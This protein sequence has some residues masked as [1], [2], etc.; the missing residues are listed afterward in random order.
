MIR[1]L[2][3]LFIVRNDADQNLRLAMLRCRSIGSAQEQDRPQSQKN[4]DYPQYAPSCCRHDHLLLPKQASRI[5]HNL[6]CGSFSNLLNSLA[7]LLYHPTF[8]ISTAIQHS[9]GPIRR[10]RDGRTLSGL[11]VVRRLDYACPG[12]GLRDRRL[13]AVCETVAKIPNTSPVPVTRVSRILSIA[14]G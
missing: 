7:K 5:I 8:P 10:G 3:W 14:Q 6:P 13:P 9:C 2:R 1:I 12:D 4:H 11:A